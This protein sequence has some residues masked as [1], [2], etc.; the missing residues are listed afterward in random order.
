MPDT[1]KALPPSETTNPDAVADAVMKALGPQ[2]GEVVTNAVAAK[3][4]DLGLDRIDRK[5]GIFPGVARG[6]DADPQV[7]A[8]AFFRAAIFGPRTEV[9]VKALSEGTDSAGGYLVPDDFRSQVI[10]RTNELSVLYP[11]CFKFPTSRDSVKIPNLSTDVEVSW[12]EAENASFDESDAALGQTTFTIHRMNAITY[13]S[14]ELVSDSAVNLVDLLSRLFADAVSRERDKMIC[15]GDG[16]GQP[17]G[18][19]SATGVT[20]VSSIGGIGHADL[21]Q[22][23]ETI[24]EQY[25]SDASL[26]WITNQTVRRY[27]RTIKDSNGQPVLMRD[28]VNMKA[29]AMLMGHPLLINTNAP[30]GYIALGALSKYWIADREILGFESTTTG[31]D[32]FAKHQIGLKLWERW[33]G[34]LVYKTDC[35]VIGSGITG[36]SAT[37]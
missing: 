30:S 12:D 14:R 26:V 10:M 13:T 15:V 19:F 35:W 9:E 16:S 21:V 27:I 36:A 1:N 11:R 37:G 25:R 17:E 8:A 22:M 4:R 3:V 24:A 2:L 23:D 29:P 28:P 31:G 6:G 20:A 33:D 34:K 18:V 32:T 7:R 5:R